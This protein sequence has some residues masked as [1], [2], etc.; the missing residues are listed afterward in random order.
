MGHGRR[1]QCIGS[2]S[3]DLVDRYAEIAVAGGVLFSLMG[4]MLIFGG[5][6]L[7]PVV[8]V[9]SLFWVQ[10]G[11]VEHCGKHSSGTWCGHR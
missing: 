7:R 3:V 4:M 8:I 2:G 5:R 6:K 10:L 11:V 1:S 9:L